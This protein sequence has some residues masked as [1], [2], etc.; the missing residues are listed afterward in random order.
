[1][2]YIMEYDFIEY[3][4]ED[5]DELI[6]SN[7]WDNYIKNRIIVDMS[8]YQL[9]SVW[10]TV[11]DIGQLFHGSLLRVVILDHICSCFFLSMPT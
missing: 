8:L 11:C 9:C 2:W 3:G 7:Y 1:M 6:N 4:P 10:L 5:R